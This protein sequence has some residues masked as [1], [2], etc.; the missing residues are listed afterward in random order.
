MKILNNKIEFNTF[1]KKGLEKQD[2]R[3]G[4]Y[5]C[6]GR[7]GS[8][9]SYYAIKLLLAQDKKSLIEST[10]TFILCIYLNMILNILQK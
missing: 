6:C 1:I 10:L 7:Q 4:V 3:F 5:F 9:K 2:D 8:G